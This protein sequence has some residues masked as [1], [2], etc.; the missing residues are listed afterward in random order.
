MFKDVASVVVVVV[1]VVDS[2]DVEA[3]VEVLSKMAVEDG[4]SGII[5]G[6]LDGVAA[7]SNNHGGNAFDVGG[8]ELEA[9]GSQV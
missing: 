8:A 1:E 5:S 7:K 6:T 3:K 9:A 4:T 2:V